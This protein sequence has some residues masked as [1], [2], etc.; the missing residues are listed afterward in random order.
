[1]F[2]IKCYTQEGRC[3]IR[4]AESFTILRDD[5]TG[6]A[7]ITLHTENRSMSERV[8]IV[9][10]DQVRHEGWAPA[11]QRAYIVNAAGNT[12]ERIHLKPPRPTVTELLAILN[13]EDDRKVEILTDGSVYVMD[14]A[15]Q[16]GE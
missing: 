5:K 8:D 11:F 2:T 4:S 10:A 15:M 7:E 14:A 9:P 3:I 12:V 13:S 16:L 6:E 1:M